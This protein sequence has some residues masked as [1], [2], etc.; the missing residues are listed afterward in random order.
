M[1]APSPPGPG[2]ETRA[3]AVA[4]LGSS[5]VGSVPY[6]AIGLYH[7]GMDVASVLLGRYAIALMILIPLAIW[8]SPGLRAEWNAAGRG[9]FLNGL[10]LGVAQTYTY[11]RAVESF[12]SSVV[13]TVFFVYPMIMLA[14]D[15]Y[16]FSIT[17]RWSSIAAVG[18][19]FTGAMLA[20]WPSLSI[21]EVDPVGILCLLATPFV[22]SA[23][24]AIAYRYTRQA[25]PFVG[26]SAIYLGIGLGYVI[27]AMFHGLILPVDAQAW[28]SLLAIAIVG[29][30]IPVVSFAYAL[31]RLSGARYSIIVSLE[32]VTVV[33]IGVLLLG[34]KLS[35][36]QFAGIALVGVGIIADRLVRAKR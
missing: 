20:G 15:R 16:L 7:G 24:V 6:F 14:V 19:I 35:A 9:L 23:Y 36:I 18:L 30:V 29:G 32:L 17:P 13:I 1:S 11:F 33:T 25:T 22:Y 31:P 34:E 5:L 2:A 8:T 27:V 28:Q 10:T 21:G 12:P 26:A 4:A 3:V